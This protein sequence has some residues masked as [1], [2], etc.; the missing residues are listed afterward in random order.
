MVWVAPPYTE[1]PVPQ[2]VEAAHGSDVPKPRRQQRLRIAAIVGAVLLAAVVGIG[3]GIGSV[4]A[5]PPTRR[6]AFRTHPAYLP[7]AA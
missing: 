3:I 7:S 6:K 4:N 1:Q 5:F 2:D